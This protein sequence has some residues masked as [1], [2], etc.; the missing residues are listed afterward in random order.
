MR[1]LVVFG[2][3]LVLGAAW[4]ACH[5]PTEL[6]VRVTT[7]FECS[8]LA[9]NAVSVR[10]GG[11][12]PTQGPAA[13]LS[14]AC[15]ARY[16]GT[17]VVAPSDRGDRV[18]VEVMAAISPATLD[19]DGQ[20]AEGTPGCI[21]ARRLLGYLDGTALDVKIELQASCAGRVCDPSDT[22]VDSRCVPAAID[23]NQ[24]KI[25][26]TLHAD[27]GLPTD[28]GADADASTLPGNVADLALGVDHSCA[29]LKTGT[30]KCWGSNQ[31]GQLATGTVGGTNPVPGDVAGLADVAA[32][33]GQNMTSVCALKTT[34]DLLCWGA[35][36]VGQLAN[37]ANRGNPFPTPK[38]SSVLAVKKLVAAVD[39]GCATTAAGQL[40]CWSNYT[41]G[42][43]ADPTTI[44]GY[45][46]GI[47]SL[48]AGENL[49]VFAAPNGSLWGFGSDQ[50]GSMPFDGGTV[51]TPT[52]LFGGVLVTNVTSGIRDTIVTL[53]DGGY[54]GWGFNNARQ[55]TVDQFTP[56]PTLTPLPTLSGYK[57]VCLGST[58]GCG[59][60]ASDT[61]RCWGDNASKQLGYTGPNT[62]TPVVVGTGVTAARVWCGDEHACALRK[63]D[64][65]LV[66]WGNN[67]SG[68]LG[69]GTVGG[70][71]AVP[72]AVG[73]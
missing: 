16:A 65:V 42:A 31:Y 56:V 3:P 62:A 34:G 36:S 8:A 33:E 9:N 73:L 58:F 28:G 1:S 15:A 29:L 53:P 24:C 21:H 37:P 4:V 26:C 66:C 54:A 5:E 51:A 45:D 38:P 44:T 49:T 46:G 50:S 23:P 30:V 63:A 59:I 32:I 40:V 2:F 52:P 67:A 22:C 41:K 68:Q 57:D 55:L 18:A 20:C 35:S 72:V 17:V 39:H 14:R 6:K 13:T 27:G 48:S 43:Q 64:G 71:N 7:D 60:D 25:D 69:G 61:V 70:T 47:A 10:V 19:N 12:F 11:S